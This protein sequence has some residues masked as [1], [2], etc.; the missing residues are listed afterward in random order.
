MLD[1][2]LGASLW[3]SCGVSLSLD[4][5][6]SDASGVLPVA[7]VGEVVLRVGTAYFR[8]RLMARMLSLF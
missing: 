3:S 2:G 4:D 1:S 5:A 7:G 6:D 8:S